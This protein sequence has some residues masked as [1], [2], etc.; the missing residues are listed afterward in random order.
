MSYQDI[1]VGHN[2]STLTD[3]KQKYAAVISPFQALEHWVL[4]K[5]ILFPMQ[6]I[7]SQHK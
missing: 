2:N 6:L 4:H 7:M 1:K 5:V 3:P